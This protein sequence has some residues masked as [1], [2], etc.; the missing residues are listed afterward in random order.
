[1]REITPK[2]EKC[3]WGQCPALYEVTPADMKCSVGMSCPAVFEE[4]T[5]V[6]EKC[7]YM[8]ACPAL[9][10]EV[11]PVAEKCAFGASCPALYEQE[12]GVLI[13]GKRIAIPEAIAH[14]VGVDEDVLWVPKELLKNI[15][16]SGGEDG[17]DEA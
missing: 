5:P 1:M 8:A 9:F 12:D 3:D 7:T 4:I 11:T 15:Q 16:W 6:A 13:I 10:E 17:G 14:R 2:A